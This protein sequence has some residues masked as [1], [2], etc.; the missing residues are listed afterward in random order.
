MVAESSTTEKIQLFFG[1]V[2]KNESGT[3]IVRRSYHLERTLGAPDNSL[4]TEIQTEYLV[5]A[6][7][8][9]LTLNIP[10]ANLVNVDLAFIATDHKQRTGS[11]GPLQSSVKN[12]LPSQ[13]FN[14]TSDFSRIK[15]ASVSSID[16]APTPLFVF[17]TE[18]TLTIN[19]N[20]SPNKAVGVLGA[21]DITAGTFTVSGSLTAYFGN[22]SSIAAVRNNSDITLDMAMVKDNQGIVLDIPLVSLGDGRLNV[23]QDQPITIPLS[24]DAAS[25]SDVDA[26]LGHTILFTYFSYLPTSAE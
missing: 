17:L 14:T 18:A 12:P 19:N 23:E 16:E 6:V 10:T 24:L 11:Q 3:D 22:V 7:P 21:F 2:L 25:A 13:V 26:A 9:E 20:L 8:N 5:G 1:D 4:P 15:M